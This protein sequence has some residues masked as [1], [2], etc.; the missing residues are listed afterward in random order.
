MSPLLKELAD[1]AESDRMKGKLL[2][3]KVKSVI[4]QSEQRVMKTQR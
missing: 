4:I 3:Y 1:L 2:K